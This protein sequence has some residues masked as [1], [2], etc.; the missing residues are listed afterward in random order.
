[1]TAL[2]WLLLT[3]PALADIPEVP[4]P[5]EPPPVEAPDP[6]A[7]MAGERL[8]HPSRPLGFDRDRAR[9]GLATCLGV[10]LDVAGRLS[11]ATP[12]VGLSRN[13][14]LTRSRGEIGLWGPGPLTARF[15]FVA[16]RSGAGAS[17]VGIDGE[18]FVPKVQI[19]EARVDVPEIGVAAGAG[20]IDDL[21]TM[22]TDAWALR[23]VDLTV[24]ER[25]LGMTRSDLGGWL[26]WTAPGD[27]VSLTATLTTG[28]GLDRRERNEGKNL[29]G[30]LTIR[31]LA[32]QDEV[33]LTVTV[34]GRDGSIGVETARD[35]RVGGRIVARHAYATG[36]FEALAGWGQQG[37]AARLPLGGSLW[38]HT[39]P[40]VPWVLGF[41][42]LDLVEA[43]RG[44]TDSRSATW[45]L[46]A[47]PLVPIA[48]G[49]RA[50]PLY[51]VVGYEGAGLAPGARAVAGADAAAQQHLVY[52][53]LG[54]RADAGVPLRLTRGVLPE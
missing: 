13:L 14:D 54:V 17:Y 25:R 35:H 36:G 40:D 18:A 31:P 29:A 42:R 21:W 5:P 12:D 7:R 49:S 32:F 23:I 1:M 16:T 34:Y 33:G 6:C 47:G 11:L 44:D 52:L 8:L 10:R 48:R 50:R 37:D 2:T 39:G 26:G 4:Q 20:M 41:A 19:A 27:W 43:Q 28:E 24:G 38:A 22:G 9:P 30:E 53:Q 3:A 15:A 51:A 45:K 46:G